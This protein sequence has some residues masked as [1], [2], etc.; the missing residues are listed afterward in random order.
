MDTTLEGLIDRLYAH[1]SHRYLG[2]IPQ[3][4]NDEAAFLSFICVCTGIEALAG[5]RHP[6]EELVASF[7][8]W[9]ML[10]SCLEKPDSGG[11]VHTLH[12]RPVKPWAHE[13]NP[14]QPRRFPSNSLNRSSPHLSSRTSPCPSVGRSANW[15]ITASSTSSCGCSTRGCSGS[16]CPCRQ[17]P[18][19][20][21][22]FT[23]RP[24]TKSLPNGLMMGR[25]GR[26][27]WRA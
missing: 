2:V 12:T 18:R 25:S 19:G 26:R 22:P 17:T 7:A 27:S 14:R 5:Y 20:N 4:I 15:V 23:I 1:F 11:R 10:L 16:A 6:S 9:P 8:H 13:Q 3:L 21:R 24:S